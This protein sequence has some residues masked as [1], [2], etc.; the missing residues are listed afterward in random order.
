MLPNLKNLSLDLCFNLTETVVHKIINI[1]G[2]SI[3]KLD[4][5]SISI[6]GIGDVGGVNPLS[7]LEILNLGYCR[8]VTDSGLKEKLNI[9]ES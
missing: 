8:M 7:H 3:R 6:P 9:S 5:S 2:N 4:L 1:V